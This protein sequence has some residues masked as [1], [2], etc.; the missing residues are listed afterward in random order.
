M[1][2]EVFY[3]G[4]M[5]MD[6]APATDG[7]LLDR[8]TALGIAHC[9]YDHPAVFTVE[10]SRIHCAHIPG[11]HTKN[12]FLEDRRGGL[13]LVVARE[14]VRIDLKQ[15]AKGLGLARFSFGAPEVL[16]Q[17]LGVPP[18]SVTPFSLINDAGARVHVVLDAGMMDGEILNFH[19]LR[20]DRTTSVSPAGLLRFLRDTGHQPMIIALPERAP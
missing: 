5:D 18:G 11:T 17:A 19:P 8:L 6:I 10:E 14:H 15:L 20:N 2:P 16:L 13:W 4:G 1:S 7:Q 3:H 12:L 9:T